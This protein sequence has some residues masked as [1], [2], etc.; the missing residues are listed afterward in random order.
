MFLLA[1][2][3]VQ[4]LKLFKLFNWVPK[5]D[6][7]YKRYDDCDLRVNHQINWEHDYTDKVDEKPTFYIKLA[8]LPKIY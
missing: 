1:W 4:I 6:Q 2:F 8:Y 5:L 3:Y 7:S